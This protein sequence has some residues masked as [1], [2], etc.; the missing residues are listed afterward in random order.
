MLEVDAELSNPCRLGVSPW[1]R[2]KLVR[3]SPKMAALKPFAQRPALSVLQT[4]FGWVIPCLLSA[5][6]AAAETIPLPRD[7]PTSIPREQSSATEATAQVSP[8]Q[9]RL[10]KIAEF[11]PAPSIAGPGECTATDVV[12]VKAVLLPDWQRVVFSTAA[13]LRCTMAEEVA[14][15]IRDDVARTIAALG[16]A[17]SG[18][19]VVGSYDCRSFNGIT[20]TRT[21]E[22]GR[23]NALDVQAFKLAS[24]AIIQLN[25]AHVPKSL[26]E[27]L[28][29]TACSR[30]STVLGNG[31]DEFHQKHI[32]IDLMQ[33]TNSYKI[34][35]WDVLDPSQ[36]AALFARK[37]AAGTL[38][39]AS[40]SMGN[41]VP[42]PRPRPDIKTRSSNVAQPFGAGGLAGRPGAKKPYPTTHLKIIR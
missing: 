12:T 31:A 28:R 11:E 18:V 5:G 37:A 36:T 27:K 32:H 24:G 6:T 38:S 14:R 23:A 20:G 17:V 33:R 15:W 9:L 26:R 25:D 10:A 39:A 34:C 16:T 8:C 29:Q 3:Q 13:T 22:H 35:Q 19:E 21:S 30:F 41:D 42:L 1:A 40:A 7:R 4:I 2:D